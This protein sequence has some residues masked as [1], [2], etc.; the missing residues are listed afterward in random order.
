MIFVNLFNEI[1]NEN[2]LL[3]NE[4]NNINTTDD[5][6]VIY[7]IEQKNWFQS[8]NIYLL[9]FYFFLVIILSYI[10]INKNKSIYSK[11]FILSFFILF[12]FLINPI[13][14]FFYNI[15]IYILTFIKL[16]VYP[17]N[18]LDYYY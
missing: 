8:I 17:G 10:I 16:K 15:Y 14:L 9:L 1:F 7:E 13:E 5:R 2:L 11:T 18:A 4:I 12:P 6:K 3:K